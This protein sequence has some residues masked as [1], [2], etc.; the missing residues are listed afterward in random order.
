MKPK[1]IN[2]MVESVFTNELLYELLHELQY[3]LFIQL[4]YQQICVKHKRC[5]F[6]Y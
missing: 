2:N 3:D 5:N 1:P 4:I 6:S